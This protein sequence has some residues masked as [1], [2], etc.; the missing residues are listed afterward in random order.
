MIDEPLIVPFSPGEAL[1][2]LAQVRG[3]VASDEELASQTHIVS[4]LH[5]VHAHLISALADGDAALT[6]RAFANAQDALQLLYREVEND[7][8]RAQALGFP[9]KEQLAD[10]FAIAPPDEKTVLTTFTL[11]GKQV[12]TSVAFARAAGATA[13]WLHVVR[14]WEEDGETQRIEDPILESPVPLFPRVRLPVGKQTLRLKSRN[15]S[16]SALSPEFTIEVPALAAL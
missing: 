1:V 15:P 14:Y 16:V 10:A 2:R 5:E 7:A 8:A 12:L 6:A 4:T 13:Y 3:A 11:G 9:A